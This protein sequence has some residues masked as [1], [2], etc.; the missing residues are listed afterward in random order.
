MVTGT[1]SS[2]A[3]AAPAKRYKAGTVTMVCS[4]SDVFQRCFKC[5]SRVDRATTVCLA[6]GLAVSTARGVANLIQMPFPSELHR[7]SDLWHGND[8]GM[9]KR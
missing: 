6:C 9:M 3:I 8:I 7:F 5:Q 2:C 4:V 1:R